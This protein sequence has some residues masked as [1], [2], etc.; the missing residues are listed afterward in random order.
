MGYEIQDTL[1]LT[2]RLIYNFQLL[3][4]ISFTPYDDDK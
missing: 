4:N 3:T 2:T 1:N